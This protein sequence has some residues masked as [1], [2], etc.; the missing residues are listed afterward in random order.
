MSAPLT[1]DQV[2][3]LTA[4]GADIPSLQGLSGFGL[5]WRALTDFVGDWSEV[6]TA[7]INS[8]TLYAQDINIGGHS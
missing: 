5:A 8:Y 3:Q 2:A 1:A 4:A 6:F 7:D